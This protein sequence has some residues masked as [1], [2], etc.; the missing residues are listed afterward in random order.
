MEN[1]LAICYIGKILLLLAIKTNIMTEIGFAQ[2]LELIVKAHC[3]MF[4]SDH[5]LIYCDLM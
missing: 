1:M 3:I 2:V 4:L 5:E